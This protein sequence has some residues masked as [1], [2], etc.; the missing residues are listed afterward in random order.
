MT[1]SSD[2]WPGAAGALGRTRE[3]IVEA[4]ITGVQPTLQGG[5]GYLLGPDD[6]IIEYVG[7]QPLERFNH[8]HMWQEDPYCA[9]VWYQTHLNAA[10]GGRAR[11]DITAESCVVERDPGLTFPALERDGMYRTPSSA[12]QFDDVA[13]TWYMRQGDEPLVPTRGQLYDHVALGVTD[14]DAW[15]AKL[16]AEDV[17][18]LEEPHPLGNTRAAMIEGPSLEAIE[19]VEIK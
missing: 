16:R 9:Q 2:T 1:V 12:V 10:P 18:F 19:L 17:T 11:A 5:F 4:K 15:I 6:A 14:L 7:N 3:Q 8:V 13:F